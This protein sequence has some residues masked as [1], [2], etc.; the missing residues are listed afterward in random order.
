MTLDIFEGKLFC[1]SF[2]NFCLIFPLDYNHVMILFAG[3][4]REMM[5]YS[6]HY[7]FGFIFLLRTGYFNKIL[8]MGRKEV[9]IY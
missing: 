1:I 7:C 2:L 6:S 8:E 3:N 4:N 9:K 5:L